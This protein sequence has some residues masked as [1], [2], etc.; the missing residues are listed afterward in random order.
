[1]KLTVV[2][3]ALACVGPTTIVSA[4]DVIEFVNFNNLVA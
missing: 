4:K 2:V 1:M 3:E